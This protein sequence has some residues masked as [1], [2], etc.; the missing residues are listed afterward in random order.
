MRIGLQTKLM[1]LFLVCGLVPLLIATAFGYSIARRA[2]DQVQELSYQALEERARDQ[3]VALLQSKRAHVVS[4]AETVHREALLTARSPR[5]ALAFRAVQAAFERFQSEHSAPTQAMPIWREELWQYYAQTFVPEYERLNGMQ[6]EGLRERFDLLDDQTVAMQHAFLLDR[7]DV[8]AAPSRISLEY[9]AWEREF[10]RQFQV[11]RDQLGYQDLMLVDAESGDVIFS[12]MQHIDFGT[13]LKDGPWAA[14]GAGEAFRRALELGPKKIELVFTDFSSYLPGFGMPACFISMPVLDEGQVVGVLLL[15]LGID[16]INQ[17]MRMRAGQG[18]TGEMLLVGPDYLL[19]SDSVLDS[20]GTFTVAG[21]F[22][23]PD[24]ARM[25]NAATRAVFERAEQGVGVFPDYRGRDTLTAYAPVDFFGLRW[26][27]LAKVDTS[28]AFAGIRELQ[29]TAMEAGL[30]MARWRTALAVGFCALLT[31]LAIAVTRPIV[32]PLRRT[33]AMLQ[34]MAQ[35]EGDLSQ[36]LEASTRDEIADLAYW[37][38]RFMGKL[39]NL[40]EELAQKT[41]TLE[42]YHRELEMRSE[43]LEQEVA[44]RKRAEAEVLRREEY[45]KALIENAPDV[46]VVTDRD[47]TPL[48]VSPSFQ[49]TFGYEPSEVLGNPI[50]DLIHPE[51]VEQRDLRRTESLAHPGEPVRGEFRVK[52]RDGRWVHVEG[53]G[54]SFLDSAV[55]RGIVLNLRDITAR[56]EAESLLRNYSERLERE[57]AER[58]A[59]LLRKSEDLSHALDNLKQTQD[60][61]VMNQKMASLGAL[62]AGIAHEIKNPLNFVNNFAELCQELVAELSGEVEQL[63]DAIAGP[64]LESIREMLGDLRQNAEKIR[65]HGRRADSIVRNM[66]LHSRGK[67]GHRQ[68][69]DINALLDEYVKLAYHGMR[70]KDTTFNV[71]IMTEFDPAMAPIDVVPQDISRVLINILNNACYAVQDRAKSG[72]AGYRPRIEA[73]T[74]DLGDSVEIRVR[75]NGPGVPQE[76]QDKIFAPFF[77]TKPAGEGTGLGLSIS[78]D[79]IVH[80]HEGELLV[81]SAPGEFAE[82]IVRL[83]KRVSGV[84]REER[85]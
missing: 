34:S 77:T 4:Y 79:I 76:I 55:V 60:Q 74:R 58:T 75:D 16:H 22:R 54:T 52:H 69:T 20:S 68:T 36:R 84:R 56:K 25:E 42:R 65:E 73:R 78:Y 18:K 23:R 11:A 39:Q 70:A 49:N 27:L 8:A 71:D 32:R 53:I 35:G 17:I 41:V 5:M 29:R 50:Q 57:V 9:G 13:S 19:R 47:G 44:E 81:E 2:A 15:E 31:L 33:V 64:R 37:F 40:Y 14:T 10:G 24:R 67:P 7:S 28:E 48:Y 12:V 51:D 3:L 83:P 59:E 62:T 30:R 38:N 1:L 80:E 63:G 66:L 21:S 26:C 46:I 61:L 43:H 6:P 72:E 85:T 45:F 82:F